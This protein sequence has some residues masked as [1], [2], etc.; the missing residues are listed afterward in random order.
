MYLKLYIKDEEECFNRYPNTEKR[1]EKRRSVFNQI[2]S[3]WI[4]DETLFLSFIASQIFLQKL[5]KIILGEIQSEK[6]TQFYDN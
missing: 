1:V 5:F 6:F 3:V 2:R 4:S